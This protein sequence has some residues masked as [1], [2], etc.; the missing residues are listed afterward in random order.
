MTIPDTILAIGAHVFLASGLKTAHIVQKTADLFGLIEG[1]DQD[2]FGATGVLIRITDHIFT[3]TITSPVTTS[4]SSVN[5]TIPLVV[6]TS[7]DSFASFTLDDV[8]STGG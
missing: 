8:S 4:G 2:F 5:T 3:I 7:D 1:P 6:F